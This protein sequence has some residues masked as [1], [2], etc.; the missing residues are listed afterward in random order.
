MDNIIH[1]GNFYKHGSKDFIMP[2]SDDPK[3]PLDKETR[4]RLNLYKIS[5]EHKSYQEAIHKL[6]DLAEGKK[7]ETKKR[8]TG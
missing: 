2:K 4:K 8:G 6:L 7:S 1:L 3:I 5:N